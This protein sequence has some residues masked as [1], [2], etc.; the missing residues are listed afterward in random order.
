MTIVNQQW[1]GELREHQWLRVRSNTDEWL[2]A[3]LDAGPRKPLAG[4]GDTTVTDLN[5]FKDYVIGS[6][7]YADDPNGILDSVIKLIDGTI[8]QVEQAGQFNDGEHGIS[9]PP[10]S[11]PDPIERRP[12]LRGLGPSNDSRLGVQANMANMSANELTPANERAMAAVA[13]VD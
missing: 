8:D 10:P 7:Q 1:F 11:L 13:N 12:P 4:E 2:D 6:K 5:R 3:S 9:H